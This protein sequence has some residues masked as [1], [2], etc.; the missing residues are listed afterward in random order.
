M[1]FNSADHALSWA[2]GIQANVGTPKCLSDLSYLADGLGVGTHSGGGLTKL[3]RYHQALWIIALVD[4]LPEMQGAAITARRSHDV[5]AIEVALVVLGRRLKRLVHAERRFL[6][7]IARQWAGAGP[8]SKPLYRW[9]EVLGRS[10]RILGHRRRL[11]H[12]E[13]RIWYRGGVKRVEGGLRER[14]LVECIR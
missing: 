10:P 2:Y 14:G 6:V 11:A 8:M 4:E 9:A 5:E 1:K 3:E 13:L 12:E 7:E